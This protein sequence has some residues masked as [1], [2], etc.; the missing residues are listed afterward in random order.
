MLES[1]EDNMIF[2]M[3]SMIWQSPLIHIMTPIKGLVTKTRVLTK[4]LRSPSL[5]WWSSNHVQSHQDLLRA[6]T[7]PWQ[8]LKV[9]PITKIV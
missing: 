3:V 4:S 2:S 5:V 9:T 8:A 1:K 6:S 7:T